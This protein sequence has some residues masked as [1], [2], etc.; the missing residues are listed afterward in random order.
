VP[1]PA[2]SVSWPVV[3]SGSKGADVRSAQQLL[4][5]RGYKISAD[6]VFGPNTRSAVI[7]FQKS[8]SLAADGVIG[9]NT[10]SKL[11]TTV[12]SG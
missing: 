7:A 6:G 10:W 12:K 11:I 1:V 3:K 2:P 4:I 5:A 9:P 8:R